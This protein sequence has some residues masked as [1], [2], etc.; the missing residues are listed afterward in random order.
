MRQR[1]IYALSEVIVISRNKNYY[2]NMLHPWLQILS[3]NAFGNYKNLLKELTVADQAQL[4]E[5]ASSNAL[6]AVTLM[7]KLGFDVN[8]RGGDFS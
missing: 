3:K 6:P 5:A 8:T 7:L 1:V 2:P 4:N